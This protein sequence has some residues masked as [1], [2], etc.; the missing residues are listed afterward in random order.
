MASEQV[1]SQREP[2]S[3]PDLMHGL[4]PLLVVFIV[5][6]AATMALAAW[7][8]G[9]SM[10]LSAG[11]SWAACLAGALLGHVGSVY[12]RGDAYIVS[13]L[14]LSMAAR[15]GFPLALLVICKTSF[16][17]LFSQGM[18]YFV[19]LFYLVGLLTDLKTRMRMLGIEQAAK[20]AASVS[21]AAKAD[22]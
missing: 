16:E 15:A 1:P 21:T 17:S 20:K 3:Q 2:S 8:G 13:R 19:I 7:L 11:L 4:M 14:Y 12:P 18:V 22:G 9:S 10:V 5:T 6:G